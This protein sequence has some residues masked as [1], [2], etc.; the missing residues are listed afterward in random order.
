MIPDASCW[1]IEVHNPNQSEWNLYSAIRF[2]QSFAHMTLEEVLLF[3]QTYRD[4]P[5]RKLLR[6]RHERTQEIILFDML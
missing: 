3:V 4:V 6:A 5:N 1:R 2:R